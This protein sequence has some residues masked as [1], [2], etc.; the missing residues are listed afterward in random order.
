MDKIG[1]VPDRYL[2]QEQRLMR[3]SC[4][5][6][7]DEVVRRSSPRTE[8]PAPAILAFHAGLGWYREAMVQPWP[9]RAFVTG[10]NT[11]I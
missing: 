8:G 5:R 3:Q 6:Y 1:Q 9:L 4:R 10:R 7:V 11:V 2:S